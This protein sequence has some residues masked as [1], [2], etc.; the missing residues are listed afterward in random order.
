MNEEEKTLDLTNPAN[1]I[2]TKMKYTNA[3]GEVIEDIVISYTKEKEDNYI[4]LYLVNV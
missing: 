2:G 1:I 4:K 3:D